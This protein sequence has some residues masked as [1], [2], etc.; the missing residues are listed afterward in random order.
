MPHK[1]QTSPALFIEQMHIL[2]TCCPLY[3]DT[4]VF[5]TLSSSHGSS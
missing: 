3:E 5:E 4:G 2:G 1:I